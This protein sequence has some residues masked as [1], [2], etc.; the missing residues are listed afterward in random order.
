MNFGKPI[1]QRKSS[2]R[3]GQTALKLS[4]GTRHKGYNEAKR[5][6]SHKLVERYVLKQT[7]E[8]KEILFRK[9]RNKS[10]ANSFKAKRKV[11]INTEAREATRK[12]KVI[13]INVSIRH[14]KKNC[15]GMRWEEWIALRFLMAS[16]FVFVF[17][18]AIVRLIV[19]LR[20]QT[21]IGVHLNTKYLARPCKLSTS[22][23][24][25]LSLSIRRLKAFITKYR[26]TF[27]KGFCFKL[28]VL[29]DVTVFRC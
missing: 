22:E 19:L 10:A 3:N 20:Y 9:H 27:F 1:Q 4:S 21:I 13:I 7:H 6:D 29:F 24:H 18:W 5:Q 11:Y 12:N 23:I 17:D 26:Y 16:A 15:L 2:L 8:R 28:L 14:T 25:A